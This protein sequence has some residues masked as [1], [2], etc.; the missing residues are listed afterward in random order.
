MAILKK[1]LLDKILK[2]KFKA[3]TGM[4]LSGLNNKSVTLKK[5]SGPPTTAT[6]S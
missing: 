2:V 3:I 1:L 4:A 5:H 6:N